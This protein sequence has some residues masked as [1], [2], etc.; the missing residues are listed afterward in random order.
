MQISQQFL[1][2]GGRTVLLLSVCFA[3]G[4]EPQRSNYESREEVG[5]RAEVEELISRGQFADAATLLYALDVESEVKKSCNHADYRWIG[6]NGYSVMVPG[7]ESEEP[8]ITVPWSTWII[9]GT[10][11][12]VDS[13]A[14]EFNSVA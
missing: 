7:M 11:D 6:V 5:F 13:E 12:A 4:C 2:F 9:P 14:Q 10:S 1:D 8:L 3:I